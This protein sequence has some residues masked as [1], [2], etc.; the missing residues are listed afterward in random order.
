MHS[1]KFVLSVLGLGLLFLAS[2]AGVF[3]GELAFSTV[4]IVVS[5]VTGNAFITGKALANGMHDGKFPVAEPR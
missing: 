5:Y 2:L 1:T 4:S 3:S